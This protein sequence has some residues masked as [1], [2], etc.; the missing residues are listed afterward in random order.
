M[1]F[2]QVS[3]S[4]PENMAV[5]P[6][7]VAVSGDRTFIRECE[8]QDQAI[9][10]G[11]YYWSHLSPKRKAQIDEFYAGIF[12]CNDEGVADPDQGGWIIADWLIDPLDITYHDIRKVSAC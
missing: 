12:P 3:L 10:V 9:K 8:S 7:V 5:T 6:C 4:V 11:W 1:N 2:K